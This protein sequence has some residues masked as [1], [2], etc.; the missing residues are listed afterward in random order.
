MDDIARSMFIMTGNRRNHQN[1][2]M[3]GGEEE[4]EESKPFLMMKSGSSSSE[5]DEH[6]GAD[7]DQQQRH[8]YDESSPTKSSKEKATSSLHKHHSMKDRRHH[9]HQ[10]RGR[11]EIL[12]VAILTLVF[13][14]FIVWSAFQTTVKNEVKEASDTLRK[15]GPSV[16][17]C[18]SLQALA[19]YD[20]NNN[21]VVNNDNQQHKCTPSW[22]SKARDILRAQE[23]LKGLLRE[24]N[25]DVCY[26]TKNGEQKSCFKNETTGND[27]TWRYD[28]RQASLAP[29]WLLR[30]N[31]EF[32]LW[33]WPRLKIVLF[34]CPK[35]GNTQVRELLDAAS[36][37]VAETEEEDSMSTR[38]KG[39]WSEES[40]HSWQARESRSKGRFAWMKHNSVAYRYVDV[41]LKDE[42]WTTVGIIR[43]PYER[44]KSG[45]AELE[46]R[47]DRYTS[48]PEESFQA[49][50][51]DILKAGNYWNQPLET[52]DRAFAFWTD[53]VL[54]RFYTV[55]SESYC[56][57][58]MAEAYHLSPI[59]AFFLHDSNNCVPADD[60]EEEEEKGPM[61]IVEHMMDVDELH[62]DWPKFINGE[63][64]QGI[65]NSTVATKLAAMSE[66]HGNSHAASTT[67]LLMT[68]LLK[69]NDVFRQSVDEFYNNDF[70]SF[71][72]VKDPSI[73]HRYTR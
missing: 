39:G 70:E 62:I 15:V 40:D 11:F 58:P 64:Y 46:L 50:A 38:P 55:D 16:D 20:E 34:A 27:V 54:G 60:S 53:Y 42:E 67:T 61:Y 25:K 10:H 3:K 68:D 22:S 49:K 4:E 66:K 36:A 29:S 13:V 6:I 69:T 52:R 45:F 57:A 21:A 56:M 17:R 43:H 1:G 23:T 2:T 7:E 12:V 37:V 18:Y 73:L 72:F 41:L 48:F 26:T 32:G 51:I 5:D 28:A 30:R 8:P 35:C 47:W 19:E 44:L 14:G 33:L 31:Q 9:H 24:E 65:W 59:G 71:G 63:R